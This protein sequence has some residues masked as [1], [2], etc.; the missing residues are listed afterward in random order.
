MIRFAFLLLMSLAV[1]S[2]AVGAVKWNNSGGEFSYFND[3]SKTIYFDGAN[4]NKT[5][6]HPKAAKLENDRLIINL[7][8]NM[9][10][11]G[12]KKTGR[13]EI[14]KNNINKKLAVYQKFKIRSENNKI[15]DRVLI[16][17]IK[18]R[19]KRSGGS[20]PA[21]T[22]NLD[23]SPVCATYR[24][25]TRYKQNKTQFVLKGDNEH[26]LK[27][28]WVYTEQKPKGV[29]VHNWTKF[30][31]SNK[32]F[33]PLND[34]EWHTV[35]MDVY[36]HKTEGYCIIKIDG[37]TYASVKQAPTMPYFSG[38]YGDYAARIGIYRDAVNFSHTVEFDDWTVVA[39]DP[40]KG[41]HIEK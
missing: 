4:Y 9:F 18:L 41:L 31:E 24:E 8:K 13:F 7:E 36:H 28:M 23:R 5:G 35:E 32:P 22:V 17:Q 38:S 30:R 3:F 14:Q 39:Y 2:Q 12:T 11:K 26:Y 34:G 40:S 25:E 1:S 33:K 21:A 10:D 16:A 6:P 19:K 27:S 37:K 15:T 29:F 20:I